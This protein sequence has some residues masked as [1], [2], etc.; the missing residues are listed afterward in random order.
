M[1]GGLAYERNEVDTRPRGKATVAESSCAKRGRAQGYGGKVATPAKGLEPRRTWETRPPKS[2]RVCLSV[3]GTSGWQSCGFSRSRGKTSL[4][5]EDRGRCTKCVVH[6]RSRDRSVRG[7]AHRSVDPIRSGEDNAPPRP[8]GP[9]KRSRRR[10]TPGSSRS[11]G[12]KSHDEPRELT[13]RGCSS[14]D[15]DGKQKSVGHAMVT[16]EETPQGSFSVMRDLA[17]NDPLAG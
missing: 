11:M 2:D 8:V 17:R 7:S 1:N 3:E 9:P 16:R 13:R 6:E 4:G 15:R 10:E 14:T 5:G 12:R